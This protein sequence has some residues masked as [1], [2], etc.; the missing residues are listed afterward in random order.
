MCPTKQIR[1]KSSDLQFFRKYIKIF[2]AGMVFIALRQFN[3][4]NILTSKIVRWV[5][6]NN[7]AGLIKCLKLDYLN[8]VKQALI[9]LKRN[10]L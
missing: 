10:T 1:F 7:P 3:N 6:N 2:K 8:R 5:I 4:I 9:R